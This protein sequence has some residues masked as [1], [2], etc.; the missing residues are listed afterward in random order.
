MEGGSAA[1]SE[2]QLASS[3]FLAA[4]IFKGAY[5]GVSGLTLVR[6]LE[7]SG[8]VFGAKADREKV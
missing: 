7:R 6:T 8:L 1:E 2:T 5:E 3:S 4:N